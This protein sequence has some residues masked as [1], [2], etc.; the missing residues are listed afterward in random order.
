MPTGIIMLMTTRGFRVL[1]IFK[2][3]ADRTV[4]NV[5][6]HGGEYICC[7]D[8]RFRKSYFV[9]WNTNN[10]LLMYRV[11]SWLMDCSIYHDDTLCICKYYISIVKFLKYIDI[12]CFWVYYSYL[13]WDRHNLFEGRSSII[14]RGRREK[15]MYFFSFLLSK[16]FLNYLAGVISLW[17]MAVPFILPM[18]LFRRESRRMRFFNL[19]CISSSFRF[20]RE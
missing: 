17:L 13:I 8:R 6:Q 5:S 1:S 10:R 15:G 9:Q 11:L 14:L 19:N 16:G 20:C 3:N 4:V 18:S 2:R 12:S 7:G